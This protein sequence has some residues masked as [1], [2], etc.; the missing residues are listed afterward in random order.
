MT[1]TPRLPSL[2]R[3]GDATGG[4][5][6]PVPQWPWRGARQFPAA[7]CMVAMEC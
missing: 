2:L 5:A 7:M 6:K 1:R 3:E 4:L